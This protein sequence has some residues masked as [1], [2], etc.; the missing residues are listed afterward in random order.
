MRRTKIIATVG[1]ASASKERLR[2]MLLAGVDALRLNFS[3]GT[4]EEH[5]RSLALARRLASDMGRPLAVIQD[6]QGPKIRTGPLT[7]GSVE[8]VAGAPFTV[9]GRAV[10]GDQ[11]AVS[12][13]DRELAGDLHP[14]HRL[15]LADGALEL[16]VVSTD[17][18]DVHTEVVRG[19][20][21]RSHQGI[22]LPG[23]PVSVSAPTE[24]DLSDMRAGVEMGVDYVALSFVRRADDVRRARR[25]LRSLG[26]RT[27]L[28]A[29]IEKPEALD[30]LKAV[31]RASDGVLVARGD[32]GVEV[33]LEKVPLL[34]KEIIR[35]A[36][37]RGV[38]AIT[39]TQMLDSMVHQPLP[40]RAEASDVANAVI[41]GSDALMLSG[42]TAIGAYPVEAVAMLDRIIGE[43]E[44][45]W[46]PSE[47]AEVSP[48]S[49]A[50][51]LSRA[52]RSLAHDLDVRAIVA[53]TRSGRTARYL[54]SDRPR[55]PVFAFT[56][57]ARVRQ[58]LVLW[59]GVHPW[60]ASHRPSTDALVRYA[61]QE[62]LQAGRVRPGER[63]I[64]VGSTPLAR[65][66]HTNFLK[67]HV[68]RGPGGP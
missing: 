32:L 53:W 17:G 41:D 14:G 27:P 36:N 54:S 19:G 15:L 28:I 24:K 5:A 66:V 43:T 7:G 33:S 20:V 29:K 23:V 12:T 9:T 22:N 48:I 1:P 47:I 63:V 44:S 21:L 62:L 40:T 55:V 18:L 16:R 51:A 10:P 67:L 64:I 49:D 34:Q 61:E 30:S 25:H 42:E 59:W 38:L 60:L 31:L 11:Q 8:L 65:G 4:V 50:H 68:L 56:P 46:S 2:A 58:E 45:G 3:H 13:T 26:V 35:A 39:A 37:Q 6:L 52:A 57:D